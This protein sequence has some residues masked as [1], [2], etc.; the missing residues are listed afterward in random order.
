MF[1]PKTKLKK[2]LK[3]KT[4]PS[5]TVLQCSENTK[6][7]G[8]PVTQH[9][10]TNVLRKMRL[11]PFCTCFVPFCSGVISVIFPK[12]FQTCKT[13]LLSVPSHLVQTHALHL[14]R[15]H[16]NTGKSCL[17]PTT[18]LKKT[19]FYESFYCMLLWRR[20]TRSVKFLRA[21]SVNNNQRTDRSSVATLIIL[22]EYKKMLQHKLPSCKGAE[23]FS[24]ILK[25]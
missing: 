8:Y 23:L 7:T 22:G 15:Q 14:T 3:E 17:K 25:G 10:K 2:K 24:C 6:F 16:G 5:P 13:F 11:P 21:K 4:L 19:S 12:D 20:Q 1:L 9:S 18:W